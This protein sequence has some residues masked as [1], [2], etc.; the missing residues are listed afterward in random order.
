[1]RA[2]V[3]NRKRD[4]ASTEGL[5]RHRAGSCSG[6]DRTYWRGVEGHARGYAD[7]PRSHDLN[8]SLLQ[9]RDAH[10]GRRDAKKSPTAS[11]GIKPG[12]QYVLSIT[13]TSWS[14]SDVSN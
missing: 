13:Y 6:M 14:S 11:P 2:G 9:T 1:M 4:S 5:S 7:D 10:R 3:R 8:G 12:R